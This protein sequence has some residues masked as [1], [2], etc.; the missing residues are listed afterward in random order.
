MSLQNRPTRAVS[1]MGRIVSVEMG[2]VVLHD[3]TE[4]EFLQLCGFDAEGCCI[5]GDFD[6]VKRVVSVFDLA[7]GRALKVHALCDLALF[8]AMRLS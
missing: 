2:A 3:D 6:G 8:Q 4:N 7:H 5:V 1:Q